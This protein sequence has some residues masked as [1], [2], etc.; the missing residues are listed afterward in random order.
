MCMITS[1]KKMLAILFIAAIA[2]N[3]SARTTTAEEMPDKGCQVECKEQDPLVGAWALK[4]V[5]TLDG[6]APVTGFCN[7]HFNEG[8]TYYSACTLDVQ[9]QTDTFEPYGAYYTHGSG[10]WKKA[11]KRN[12]KSVDVREYLNK[13]VTPSGPCGC[14]NNYVGLPNSFLKNI[15]R[16]KLSKDGQVLTGTGTSGFFSF[17]DLSV[18]TPVPGMPGA[19]YTITGQ[20]LN[21]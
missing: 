18:M 7:F 1:Y 5:F 21:F 8:G 13:D 17:S 14:N 3:I 12:Y 16:F 4:L 10:I 11:G 9:Q 15:Q 19:T 20:R 6:F 2:T